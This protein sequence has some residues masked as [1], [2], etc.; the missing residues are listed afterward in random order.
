MTVDAPWCVVRAEY[1]YRKGSS[2]TNNSIRN[3]S[4]KLSIQRSPQRTPKGPSSEPHVT[5]RQQAIAKTPAKRSVY[6][7]VS[8]IVLIVV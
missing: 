7:I 4:R 8:V 6:Q 2:N 1:E 5:I 3:L